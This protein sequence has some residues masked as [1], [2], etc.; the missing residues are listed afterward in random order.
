MLCAWL[1][2]C[3]TCPAPRNIM[4][5]K[6]SQRHD[7]RKFR[8]IKMKAIGDGKYWVHVIRFRDERKIIME[9]RP[10]IIHDSILLD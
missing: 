6:A 1:S 9:C 7:Q 4:N 8:V 3:A 5:G 2:S 10:E